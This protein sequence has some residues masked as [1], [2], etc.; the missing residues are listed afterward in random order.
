[1]LILNSPK[2]VGVMGF[3]PPGMMGATMLQE[4][5]FIDSELADAKAS[6]DFVPLLLNPL[7]LQP[8]AKAKR[9]KDIPHRVK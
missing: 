8:A 9:A 6:S 5:V 7:S 1:M 4:K 3:P 2:L